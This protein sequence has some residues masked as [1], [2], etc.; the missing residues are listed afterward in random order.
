MSVV[1][2]LVR[3]TTLIWLGAHFALTVGYLLPPN[4]L[5]DSMRP[6]LDATIGTY[7]WQSWN[8]FAPHP[9]LPELRLLARPLTAAEAAAIPSRGL[10]S[11]G[12]YDLGTP[13]FL[14]FVENRLTA[15]ERLTRPN[16][17]AVEAFLGGDPTLEPLRQECQKNDPAVCASYEERLQAAQA[18]SSRLLTR[19]GSGFYRDIAR[20]GDGAQSIALR[21]REAQSVQWVDRYT[22]ARTTRDREIGVFPIDHSV[23][24]LGLFLRPG[25]E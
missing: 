15:Y 14:A 13:L 7:F 2:R 3:V 8:L 1:S 21:A 10:P 20:P 18:A 5:K 22:S 17:H 6:V 16:E 12:W 19:I 25:A 11:Q 24:P 23:A 9:R 4:P